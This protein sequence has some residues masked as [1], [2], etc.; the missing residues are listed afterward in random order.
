[1]LGVSNPVR[2]VGRGVVDDRLQLVRL[3]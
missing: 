2:S 1:L 3:V